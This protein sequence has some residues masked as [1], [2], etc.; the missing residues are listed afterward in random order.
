MR[1]HGGGFTSKAHF[2]KWYKRSF[3]AMM[4]F[5][6]LNGLIAWNM[7][8]E[9]QTELHRAKFARHD[10]YTWIAEALLHC[11]DP[12]RRHQREP[13]S[14]N[15]VRDA[16]SKNNP[17][18]LPGPAKKRSTCQ[19]CRLEANISNS[20]E[21]KTLA[22]RNCVAC[23]DPNCRIVA[24]NHVP[25]ASGFK[26]HELLGPGQTCFDLAHSAKG[27]LTW[28]PDLRGLATVPYKVKTSHPIVQAVRAHYGLH[29]KKV[30]R[31]SDGSVASTN[32]NNDFT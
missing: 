16:S 19:V 2:Q 7:S 11:E 21:A 9:E 6:L 22:A 20:K 25:S 28:E 12:A 24:H 23:L 30:R 13:L 18:H 29:P 3:M 26:I 1:L 31:R 17:Q 5:V 32:N 10:F 27:R 4:D 8:V 15:V 14:P